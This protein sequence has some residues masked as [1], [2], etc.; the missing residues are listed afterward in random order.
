MHNI[1]F[2]IEFTEENKH[3]QKKNKT[4]ANG[5]GTRTFQI[6]LFKIFKKAA[7]A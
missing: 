5:S 7:K 6:G 1:W 4:V 3:K 2:S